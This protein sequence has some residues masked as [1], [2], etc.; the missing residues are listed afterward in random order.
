MRERTSLEQVVDEWARRWSSHDIDALLA[1]HTEDLLVEDVPRG[2]SF[3]GP[4][5]L[6]AYADAF[7]AGYPD[8]VFDLT[9]CFA[10]NDFGS[11]EWVMRG[12]HLGDRPGLPASGKRVEVRGVSIFE[13]ANGKIRRCSEYW[14]LSTLLRQIN[15]PAAGT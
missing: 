14:D 7:F 15:Q 6:R 8:V 2:M 3:C 10:A 12:T 11:A 5:Q 9:S 4:E 13:F 1:L